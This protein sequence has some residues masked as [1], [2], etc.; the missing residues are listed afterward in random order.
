MAKRREDGP[1]KDDDKDESD[2]GDEHP[3]EH[4]VLESLERNNALMRI[5]KI[6]GVLSL[7]LA[8]PARFVLVQ[9]SIHWLLS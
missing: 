8:L 2:H 5:T 3:P 1:Q 6:R 4:R 9:A 7:S